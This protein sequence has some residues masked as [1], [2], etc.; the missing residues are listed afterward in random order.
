MSLLHRRNA[1]L[2][3]LL[4]WL[5]ALNAS[6]NLHVELYQ[7]V[8]SPSYPGDSNLFQ[9]M[10]TGTMSESGEGTNLFITPSN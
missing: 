5:M 7:Q 1:I 9:L 10:G 6:G 8:N 4:V 3:C 2:L